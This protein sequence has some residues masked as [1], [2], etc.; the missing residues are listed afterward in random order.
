MIRLHR[1]GK[2]E[3]QNTVFDLEELTVSAGEIAAV[4]GPA[5]S[6]REVLFEVLLGRARPRAGAVSVA[7]VDPAARR[8]RL[9]ELAGVVFAEDALYARQSVRSNL[10][11][12]C[13][14]RGL[15][16]GRADEALEMVGLADQGETGAG[17]LAAGQARRL[18]LPG[19]CSTDL[20]CCWR[21]SPSP[22]TPR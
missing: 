1:V 7:G 3:G 4:V 19:P 8:D 20:R 22:G 2:I 10:L 18:A 16:S 15:P 11:F 14:V 13:R 9:A 5:G 12:F 21:R 6:G 17:R